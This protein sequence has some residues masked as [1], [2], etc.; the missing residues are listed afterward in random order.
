MANKVKVIISL[1]FAILIGLAVQAHAITLSLSGED[2]EAARSSSQ[3]LYGSDA[4]GA[5]VLVTEIGLP[6]PDGGVFSEVGVPSMMPDG[7]VLFG[8]ESTLKDGK[9]HWAIYTGN[10]DASALTRVRPAI[11]PKHGGTCN[12]LID[13]DPYPVADANGLIAFMSHMPDKHDALVTYGGGTM[14]CL[15]RAGDKTNPGHRIAVLSFGSPQM[16]G[17]GEVVFNAWLDD[18]AAT[19]PAAHRQALLM[20]STAGGI[21]ELAVEGDKGPNNTQYKRPFGLP[22]ATFSSTDGTMVAFTART[23][24]G[25]A[26]FLY[27]GGAMTRLLPTG[28]VTP[29]GPV[30]YLSTGRPGLMPDGTTAV[31]TAIARIPAIF[32]LSHQSLALSLQ[33]GQLTPFGTELETLGDPVMT[34]SGAMFVGATDTDDHER[35]YV[36]DGDGAFFEVGGPEIIY[37]I[38]LTQHHH[39]IFTGTL[40]VNQHGDFAYLGGR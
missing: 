2:A 4:S 20:A 22:A 28:V 39:S 11:D 34:A 21:N 6:A 17:N 14:N 29:D 8:A 25:A 27:R 26:L 12:P 13:G 19:T 35:L 5:S 36:L 40:S 10:P 23:P 15:V 16:A 33:R 31:L 30:S 1:A 37:R 32:K 38:A 3:A 7:R 24:S 9:A 18:S